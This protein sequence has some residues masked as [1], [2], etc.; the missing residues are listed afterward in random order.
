MLEE[1]GHDVQFVDY[2][3]GNPLIEDTSAQGIKRFSKISKTLEILHYDV[4]LKQRIQYI[5]HKMQFSRKYHPILGI[6]PEK[7]YT[8][9]LDILII[10]SDEVFNCI[11][12]NTNVGYSLELFGKNNNADRLISYAASFGNTTLD[13]LILYDRQKEIGALLNKF[14]AI[15]VRDENSRYIVE[16]LTDYVPESHLD[17][18]LVYDYIGKTTEIPVIKTKEKYLILY[19]Y[20]NRI[21][22]D[23]ALWIRNFAAKK[24]WR[25]Y[26]IGGAQKC[27]DRFI[28]CSP[29]EVLAY[30]KQAEAVI[31]DTFHGT[32]FSLIT[33]RQFFTVIRKSHDDFYGNEEKLIDLVK[34]FHL[35]H[36]VS[37]DIKDAECRLD[38]TIDYDN[39]MQILE[40]ER[41]RSQTYFEKMLDIYN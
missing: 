2:R 27:A 41:L 23:E 16:T 37:V 34:K 17:P 36:Q 28:N 40:V 9:E 33:K 13:K 26:A 30:F 38:E 29:F 15:S 5:A 31:T 35:E 3:T 14:N 25:V 11:Q 22:A 24:G 8:P 18:V 39:I 10:G 32:I 12:K 6:S 20:A 7:N 1:L 4:P 21:S 19:A